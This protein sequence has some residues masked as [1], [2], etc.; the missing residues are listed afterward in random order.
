MPQLDSSFFISQLFW[1]SIIFTSFIYIA[2][3]FIGPNIN[4][5]W[6]TRE[7]KINCNLKDAKDFKVKA[8]ELSQKI[9]KSLAGSKLQASN[10]IDQSQQYI[11]DQKKQFNQQLTAEIKKHEELIK[12]EIDEI[13]QEY[14][15]N[16][17]QVAYQH[18]THIIEKI[19]QE[20]ISKKDLIKI[21]NK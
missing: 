2:Y 6:Q 17:E 11:K 10:I 15:K 12:K 21:I 20:K 4:N 13:T 14:D 7:D 16:L 3:K 19:S 9:N 1:L 18:A 5:I 8:E